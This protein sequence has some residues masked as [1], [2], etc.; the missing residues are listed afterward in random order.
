MKFSLRAMMTTA[1]LARVRLCTIDSILLISL[2]LSVEAGL[3]NSTSPGCT[4]NVWVTVM[5]RRRLLD[6]LTGQ[7][8]CPL[9]RL[10]WVS[11]LM[12]LLRVLPGE[13]PS[14][15]YGFLTTPRS[16]ATRGNRPKCRNITLA[17]RCRWVTRDLP[18]LRSP[19]LMM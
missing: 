19:P 16:M 1:T 4:V 3:L 13:C 2:G 18:S 8:P 14:I 12:V 11:N 5:C 7:S 15:R 9:V 6:N 17:D 10:M